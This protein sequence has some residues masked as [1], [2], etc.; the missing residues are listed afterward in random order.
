MNYI[1]II[2]FL[3]FL[4]IYSQLLNYVYVYHIQS[5]RDVE[6]NKIELLRIFNLIILYVALIGSL[7]MFNVDMWS[8][9][10]LKKQ[11]TVKSAQRQSLEKEYDK[12]LDDAKLDLLKEK[13][14][15]LFD[16]DIKK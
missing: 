6:P 9:K 10:L 14:N 5:V 2:L 8:G 11:K 1:T 16:G 15:Y 4:Y 7:Y 13:Y 3:L 12:T